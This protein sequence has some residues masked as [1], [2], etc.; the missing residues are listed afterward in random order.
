M[1]G[2]DV[3]QRQRGII[4]RALNT[5]AGNE[6]LALLRELFVDVN[7]MGRDDRETVGK[8][9]QHDLVIYLSEMRETKDG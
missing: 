4:S 8:V 9:A 7:L 3:I 5:E 6:L 2:A 1:K